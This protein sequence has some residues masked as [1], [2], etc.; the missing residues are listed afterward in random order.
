MQHSSPTPRLREDA[1]LNR[2]HRVTTR[3]PAPPWIA[4]LAF[5]HRVQLEQLVSDLSVPLARIT[6]FKHLVARA[7]QHAC[8]RAGSFGGACGLILDDRYGADLLPE[9]DESGWWIARPVEHPGSRP[10]RFENARNVHAM[11]REW[12]AS[13]VAKCLVAFD[14]DDDAVLQQQQL[15]TLRDLQAACEATGRELLLEVIPPASEFDA[16]ASDD[17]LLRAVKAITAAGVLP[18]WWKLPAPTQSHAWQRLAAAINQ[19]DPHCRGVL[20]LGL[21]APIEQLADQLA[22]SAPHAVCRG[23]AV[24]RTIFGETARAWFAD[25]IGDDEALGAIARR[26]LQLVQRFAAARR[27]W[28]T[29]AD[30]LP[31]PMVST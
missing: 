10:L 26:Y 20:V 24:G 7:A 11:L 13:H 28:Q 16:Q 23:F 31:A 27:S 30:T 6:Q 12:P 8:Q 9:L 18:D 17:V 4:A 14:A 29:R 5:D 21:D 15:E 22:A 1:A 25:R 2:L 19:A 3:Q